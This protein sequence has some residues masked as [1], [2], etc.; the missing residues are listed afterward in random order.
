MKRYKGRLVTRHM[1]ENKTMFSDEAIEGMISDNPKVPV[2]F[3]FSGDPIGY[4][5]KIEKEE[6]GSLL[7]TINISQ[8]ALAMYMYMVPGGFVKQENISFG[9][10]GVRT[11]NKFELTEVSI[12]HMPA[13]STLTRIK[14][15]D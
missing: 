9:P 3:N 15:A 12:T 2:R 1:T 5:E 8:D 11:I 6:D 10:D 4:V 7:C 14:K 13:D